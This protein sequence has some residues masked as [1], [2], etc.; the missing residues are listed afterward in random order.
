MYLRQMENEDLPI[1]LDMARI[2]EWSSSMAEFVLHLELNPGGCFVC[3]E[4]DTVTGGV[5]TLTYQ[6]SGWIGN[7]VV[8]RKYRLK[9]Y[10]K[11]L[12]GKA[13]R[14]LIHLPTQLLCASPMAV[15]LYSGFGFN[16][17]MNI[18]RWESMDYVFSGHKKGNN[19][20]YIMEMDR[21]LWNEDRSR[22]LG[23]FLRQKQYVVNNNG[24]IVYGQMGDHWTIGPWEAADRDSAANLLEQCIEPGNGER[25]LLDVPSQ[26]TGV[27]D[28]LNECGFRVVG[29]SLLMYKNA[30]PHISFDNIYA[31][32]S[33]GSK[34]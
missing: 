31:M 28:I 7:M 22:M 24:F 11:A 2:E 9:G 32:A 25:I 27:W 10:G 6:K 23:P 34:G 1:L 4:D 16:K 13:V 26:N 19:I 12:F 8:D 33:M 15:G 17:I 14:Y 20:E 18:Y 29:R 21:H 5:M 3:V 30:L